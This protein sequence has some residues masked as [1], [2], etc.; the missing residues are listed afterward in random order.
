MT[1]RKT[2]TRTRR[3]T[4]SASTIQDND[5]NEETHRECEYSSRQRQERGHPTCSGLQWRV[6]PRSSQDQQRRGPTCL[7]TRRPRAK[8]HKITNNKTNKK[9]HEPTHK[10]QELKCTLHTRCKKWF[11]SEYPAHLIRGGKSFL[12]QQ[13]RVK[14]QTIKKDRRHTRQCRACESSKLRGLK[15]TQVETNLTIETNQ[16]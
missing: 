1:T 16:I 9:A 6:Q 14:K 12:P 2:T 15:Q 7:P 5:K 13:M 10:T 8:S 11:A 4:A 3:P